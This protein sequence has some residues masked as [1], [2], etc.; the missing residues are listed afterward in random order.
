M[1]ALRIFSTP[2]IPQKKE[3]KG[4]YSLMIKKNEAD[5]KIMK[6]FGQI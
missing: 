4:K 2:G 3:K 1:N 5:G 6:N